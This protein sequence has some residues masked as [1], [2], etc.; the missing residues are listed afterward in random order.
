MSSGHER[1]VHLVVEAIEIRCIV[2]KAVS[3]AHVLGMVQSCP[4]A[5]A[6]PAGHHL[7][8]GRI[9]HQILLHLIGHDKMERRIS[10]PEAGKR[11]LAQHQI[12]AALQPLRHQRRHSMAR[13]AA[14]LGE[15]GSSPGKTV[16]YVGRWLASPTTLRRHER[17]QVYATSA[18]K[19]RH[20]HGSSDRLARNIRRPQPA[21]ANHVWSSTCCGTLD[22]RQDAVAPHLAVGMERRR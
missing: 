19:S 12:H 16:R 17:R 5:T 3:Q 11:L 22:D 6:P 10:P 1:Q 4:N 8:Q 21:G 7:L 9:E 2:A 13:H 20:L 18:A 14:N 15:F